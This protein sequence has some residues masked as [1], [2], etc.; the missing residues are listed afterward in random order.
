MA[1]WRG[2]LL[3]AGRGLKA[4]LSLLFVVI[5]VLILS[6]ADKRLEAVLVEASPPWLT[7]LTTSF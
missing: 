6:G 3:A 2:T 1:R 4:A 5:G 7:T